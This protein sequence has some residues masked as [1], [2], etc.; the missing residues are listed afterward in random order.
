MKKIYIFCFFLILF[1][2]SNILA[3]QG[4]LVLPT[5]DYIQT[6]SLVFFSW[7]QYL[8]AD[9]YEIEIDTNISF[10]TPLLIPVISNDTSIYRGYDQYFWRINYLFQGITIHTSQIKSFGIILLSIHRD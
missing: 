1:Y 4:T 5:N 6:D 9:E 3:Q 7:N 8:N 10:S 2:N